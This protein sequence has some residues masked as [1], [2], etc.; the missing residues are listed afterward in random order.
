MGNSC[1]ACLK[2]EPSNANP[3]EPVPEKIRSEA[4]KLGEYHLIAFLDYRN[5]ESYSLWNG[6]DL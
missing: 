4:N 1:F 3:S 2:A 6:T 5:D